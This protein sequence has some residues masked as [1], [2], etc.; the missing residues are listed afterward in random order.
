MSTSQRS[1]IYEGQEKGNSPKCEE[2]PVLFM[3]GLR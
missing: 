3:L 1:G 2:R